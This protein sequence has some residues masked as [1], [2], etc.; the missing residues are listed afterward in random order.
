MENANGHFVQKLPQLNYKGG[1]ELIETFKF[2]TVMP[3]LFYHTEKC[4]QL[5]E[6]QMEAYSFLIHWI[7]YYQVGKFSLGPGVT[8]VGQIIRI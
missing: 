4:L 2:L 8:R 6:N 7:S 3:T 1:F 5:F